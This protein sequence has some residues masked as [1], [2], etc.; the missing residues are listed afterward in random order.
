VPPTIASA[1]LDGDSNGYIGSAE[2]HWRYGVVEDG[3]E[4]LG[5]YSE[6][7]SR[8]N[9]PSSRV[10]AALHRLLD[11][12]CNRE[13]EDLSS[14]APTNGEDVTAELAMMLLGASEEKAGGSEGMDMEISPDQ[15]QRKHTTDATCDVDSAWD[16]DSVL[17]RAVEDCLPLASVFSRGC[18]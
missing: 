4:G 1:P 18:A 7:R 15:R 11:P 17:A 10:R 12:S 3:A 2:S 13:G 14:V 9:V 16:V 6:S 8:K 5:R